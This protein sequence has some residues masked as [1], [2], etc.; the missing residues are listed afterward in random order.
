MEAESVETPRANRARLGGLEI[1]L[2]GEQVLVLL[3]MVTSPFNSTH[4]FEQVLLLYQIIFP[5]RPVSAAA[6]HDQHF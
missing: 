4:V 6:V 1:E 2:V 5:N 3:L